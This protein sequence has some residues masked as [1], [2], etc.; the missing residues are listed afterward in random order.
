MHKEV[1]DISSNG[2]KVEA[3][4]KNEH[5][6]QSELWEKFQKS[7]GKKVVTSHHR[8]YSFLA[9]IEDT[10]VG[11]Y[12]SVPY[13]PH[14][15][16]GNA[17]RPALA[18]LR[19][20]AKREKAIFI[21]IEP[22][23]HFSE[24]ELQKFGAVKSKDINPAETW[25]IAL[26]KERERLLQTL[27]RRLRGYY[28]THEKKGI[29]IKKSHDPSDIRF[30][31][32]LQKKTFQSKNIHPFSQTYLAKE[33]EQDFATLYLAEYDS[34]IIAAILVFDD[35]YTRYYMQA[36][37]DKSYAKLNANGIIT[38]QAIIDAW[39]AGIK[40]FDFWGI[41][42]DDAPKDHPW[43][44]FTAFKK[45]FAGAAKYYSGT[46]D[47]PINRARFALYKLLRKINLLLRGSKGQ[48]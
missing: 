36:A 17:L 14:L 37:S 2:T 19:T 39:K 11:R 48:A 33:L 41:A 21:R 38:A 10:P 44:G 27:P 35:P 23:I 24:T 9:T 26:P 30:L 22:A 34:K 4:P 1:I 46:Y 3:S 45:S 29:T 8:D 42:P 40:E 6:L 12:L 43:A 15:S 13:G 31:A 7:L 28:N 20:V 5:I 18:D 25:V 47:I 32:D 16:D